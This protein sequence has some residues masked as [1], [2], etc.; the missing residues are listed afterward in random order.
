MKR[1]SYV[2]VKK[3]FEKR[4]YRLLSNSYK[5]CETKL[6][7]LCDKGHKH[8]MTWH[9]FKGGHGCPHCAGQAKPSFVF[10]KRQFEKEG[11]CL[12]DEKYINSRTKMVYVCPKGHKHKINWH[13]WVQGNRCLYCSDTFKKSI[14]FIKPQFEKE[15]YTLLSTEYFGNNKKL[16]YICPKGHKH[17]IRWSD[18]QQGVRCYHCSHIKQPTIEFLNKKFE[19]ELY[20]LLSRAYKNCYQKLS[21]ICPVGHRHQVSWN[22]WRGGV[23]CPE[24]ASIRF[25]VSM[26]GPGH[27]NWQGGVSKDPYCFDWTKDLK[28]Y[29]KQRDGYKCMNPYCDVK[30]QK[31]LTVHHINYNKKVCGPENLITLCRSCNGRANKDRSWHKAWYRAIMYRRYGY[32]YD[33]VCNG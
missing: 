4:G 26:S 3:E 32:I 17:S 33:E 16:K 24:C 25:S 5:N 7:Y 29:I 13:D 15:G 30:N 21:Y 20:T 22:D 11:Y 9:G 8:S 23:R 28:D 6:D 10:V 12:L 18:W 14:N 2:Y 19:E 27:P 31:D 1:L